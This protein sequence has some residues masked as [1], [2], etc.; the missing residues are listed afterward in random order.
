MKIYNIKLDLNNY[1]PM[2]VRRWHKHS[3]EQFLERNNIK[4]NSS[5]V[6][7]NTVLTIVAT[8]EYDGHLASC[9]LTS[10]KVFIKDAEITE[11]LND[12]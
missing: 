7:S 1:S 11:V 10:D 6:D 12:Q 5:N 4:V 2:M 8:E 3:L 9:I